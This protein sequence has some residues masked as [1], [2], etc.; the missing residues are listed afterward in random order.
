[1]T[2]GLPYEIREALVSVAG[3]A[4][5]LKDPLQA[6][7][8]SCGVP[9][10]MYDRY[11][12]ESKFKIARHVLADLDALGDEGTLIQRRLVTELCRLKKIP[13][14]SVENR[15]AATA[16]LNDLRKLAIEQRLFAEEKAADERSRAEDARR[17]QAAAQDRAKRVARL[18]E[19]FN[20]M[21]IATDDPHAR[22]YGLEDLLADLFGVHELQYRRSYR[23]PAE[24]IDGHFTFGGFDYLVE[25]RWRKDQ[26]NAQ[27]LM[28][29]KGK[30]DRKIAST[31]GL[32][33]SVAGFNPETVSEF[34]R[35]QSSSIVLM[36][37]QDI[38]LILE[39][40]VSLIDALTVKTQKAAQ[41]GIIFYPLIQR[42]SGR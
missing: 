18:R 15:V 17:R 21:A 35:G 33:V 23:T 28:G 5:W 29:L 19:S 39:G 34:T 41:E 38:S 7:M 14:D 12:Q 37:G 2:T 24:Q 1:M 26:P 22:G 20:A 11:A 40:H 30:V 32:F 36:D 4:F 42:F 27:D 13:D 9:R 8:L 3:R 25:A 16:A 6:F 31:R 10:A